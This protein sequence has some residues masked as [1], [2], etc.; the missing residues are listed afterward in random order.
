[1]VSSEVAA[2]NDFPP[3]AF[4]PEKI[5]TKIQQPSITM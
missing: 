1:M 3:P 2:G 4:N 5:T